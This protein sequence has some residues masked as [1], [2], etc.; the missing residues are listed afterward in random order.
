MVV[1]FATAQHARA[2]DD[3]KMSRI[4]LIYDHAKGINGM[5]ADEYH[6]KYGRPRSRLQIN[7]GVSEAFRSPIDGTVITNS[8]QRDDHMKRHGLAM[9]SDFAGVKRPDPEAQQA[10]LEK[11]VKTTIADSFQKVNQGYKPPPDPVFDKDEFE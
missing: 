10:A 2:Y 9:E 1:A 8:R 6:E 4:R 7:T 3:A 11:D 5:P